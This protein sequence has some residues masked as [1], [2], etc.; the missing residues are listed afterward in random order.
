MN[1]L[2]NSRSKFSHQELPMLAMIKWWECAG[3]NKFWSM[4]SLG[5]QSIIYQL[6]FLS[7]AIILMGKIIKKLMNPQT[8]KSNFYYTLVQITM[9]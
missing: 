2:A 8:L 4:C 1:E 5:E 7:K 9:V 6:S 3:I